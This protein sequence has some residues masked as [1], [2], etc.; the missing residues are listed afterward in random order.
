[1]AEN[2]LVNATQKEPENEKTSALTTKKS[3]GQ[4]AVF[5]YANLP[6]GQQ[7]GLPDGRRVIIQGYPV[8]KLV[9]ADGNAIACGKFGK[10]QV[11]KQDWEYI[12]RVY[13]EMAIFKSGVVFDAA[14]EK[15]GDARANEY[16][17]LRH[18]YE[19]LDPAK[20]GHQ[21]GRRRTGR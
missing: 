18:G 17:K 10:T 13:G 6:H 7:F 11:D 1:M 15:N 19:P 12:K 14:T 8:S 16:S 3:A 21:T 2:K 4:S 20:N 9:D 5:V